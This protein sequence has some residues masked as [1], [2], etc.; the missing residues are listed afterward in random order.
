MGH[1][2]AKHVLT[3]AGVLEKFVYYVLEVMYQIIWYSFYCL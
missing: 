1:R 3:S 2:I